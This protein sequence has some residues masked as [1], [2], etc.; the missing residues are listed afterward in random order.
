MAINPQQTT[1]ICD[2]RSWTCNAHGIINAHPFPGFSQTSYAMNRIN[3]RSQKLFLFRFASTPTLL[4]C[5][6]FGVLKVQPLCLIGTPPFHV[7]K[8]PCLTTNSSW[9]E[10]FFGRPPIGLQFFFALQVSFQV[11]WTAIFG[12]IWGRQTAF[13]SGPLVGTRL[14][15]LLDGGVPSY[16]GTKATG[17][18]VYKEGIHGTNPP[19]QLWG[20]EFFP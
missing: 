17:F 9:T 19:K 3:E 1:N 11:G 8:W 5:V 18:Y 12:R 13:F 10:T 20:N 14:W 6:G 2:P 16:L 4:S 7:L 15:Q